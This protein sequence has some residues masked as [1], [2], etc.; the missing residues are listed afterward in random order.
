LSPAAEGGCATSEEKK[1]RREKRPR[2]TQMAWSSIAAT[3]GIASPNSR[4]SLEIPIPTAIEIGIA[5]AVKG[6]ASAERRHSDNPDCDCDGDFDGDCRGI[7]EG[8][9]ALRGGI[10]TNTHNALPR[11]GFHQE[12]RQESGTFGD[13]STD[14]KGVGCGR[15]PAAWGEAS[16]RPCVTAGEKIRSLSRGGAVTQR[17]I[18]NVPITAR[19]VAFRA[20]PQ[21]RTVGVEPLGRALLEE[22]GTSASVTDAVLMSAGMANRHACRDDDQHDGPKP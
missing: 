8:L 13:S 11:I 4:H 9:Q 10:Q 1:R 14:G 2:I 18:V 7:A 19:K 17:M 6:I 22:K 20:F 5:I 16:L 21:N 3:K 12:F 15:W